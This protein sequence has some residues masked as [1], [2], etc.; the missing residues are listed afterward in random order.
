MRAALAADAICRAAVSA[1]S[2]S[3]MRASAAPAR[4][5]AS[6]AAGPIAGQ[7]Q[8]PPTFTSRDPRIAGDSSGEDGGDGVWPLRSR[9]TRAL[10][11]APALLMLRLLPGLKLESGGAGVFPPS[12]HA[13]PAPDASSLAACAPATADSLLATRASAR[14]VSRAAA[15]RAAAARA[16]QAASRSAA[17]S[18]RNCCSCFSVDQVTS[19]AA[20]TTAST[21]A[22][23]FAF[24][25]LA[26]PSATAARRRA[27]RS[28]VSVCDTRAFAPARLSAP[29]AARARAFATA[30]FSDFAWVSRSLAR[31]SACI[32]HARKRSVDRRATARITAQTVAAES[33]HAIRAMRPASAARA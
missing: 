22:L 15:A 28:A 25:S 23:A 12:S 17:R 16:E 8:L 11:V 29:A 26:V 1:A 4:A 5:N 6:C 24:A 3:A 14:A 9:R 7:G 13:K 10:L 32:A 2:A 30:A 18:A 33:A 20:L 27:F 31:L 21:S 19:A